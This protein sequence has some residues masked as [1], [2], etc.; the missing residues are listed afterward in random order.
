MERI[1][2]L[3]PAVVTVFLFTAIFSCKKS[4]P[5]TGNNNSS[6]P[7]SVLINIGNNI[8]LPSY[9]SLA[10]TVNSLDSGITDFNSSPDAAKLA[11]LQTLFK[12]AYVAWESVSEF[13]GFGPAS[14][15]QP[16]LSSIDLFPVATVKVDSN[17]IAG[18]YTVNI[19]SN[20]TAKGFPA[21]DYLLF[22]GGSNTLA[23]YTT[24]AH[25]ANRKQYLA[26]VSADIK[27]EVNAVVTAWSATGGNYIHTFTTG[28]GNSVS[29]SLGL[30]IN[31]VDQDLEILKNDR[32][33]IPLGKQPP[34]TTLPILPTEVEAY[35]SGISAQLALAQLKAIQGIYT[36]T[37]ANGGATMG[38]DNY[39]VKANAKYNG[40]SLSDTV[41]A[42]F[43]TAVTELQA[44]PDP[45]SATIQSNAG[46]SDVL[47]AEC[48]KLVVLMKTD[49][50]SSLGVL[51]TYGDNDGD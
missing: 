45:L 6:G 43:A 50:P 26:A 16:L 38:L 49:M 41:K 14:T 19:I 1:I 2:R 24:D 23:N 10:T 30:L 48:Q 46:P 27:T 5:G 12:N 17:I 7:D 51:I 44:I 33:G 34:G 22:G 13:N 31:S 18:S 37:S 11:N 40:G 42:N 20:A 4:S 47:Y 39:V 3:F 8:I 35:Y 21:L 32:L 15:N 28:T 29:S 36:G 9:Q 25:A